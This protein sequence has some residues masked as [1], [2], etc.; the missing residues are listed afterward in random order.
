MIKTHQRL[1]N[2]LSAQNKRLGTRLRKEI[3]E[4][5][6]I[7]KFLNCQVNRVIVLSEQNCKFYSDKL[8]KN[9]SGSNDSL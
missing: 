3:K 7:C 2:Y 9:Q 1:T 8:V 5:A 4:C 6:H